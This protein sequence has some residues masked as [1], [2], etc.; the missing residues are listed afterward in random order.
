MAEKAGPRDGWRT[1]IGGTLRDRPLS[2]PPYSSRA[3]HRRGHGDDGRLADGEYLRLL[4]AATAYPRGVRELGTWL[5]EQRGPTSFPFA[6]RDLGD[7]RLIGY[8]AID[9]VL[10]NQRNAW[11]TLAIGAPADRGRGYGQEALELLL[12]FAFGELNLRCLNITVFAYNAAAIRL[13]ERMGFRREG[14]MREF[15]ERDGEIFDMHFYGLLRSEWQA[16]AR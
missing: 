3:A 16:K 2:G 13:Y 7:D 11:V 10:W 12:G 5:S 6:I 14:S 4:D 8:A 1:A 9:G 15:L